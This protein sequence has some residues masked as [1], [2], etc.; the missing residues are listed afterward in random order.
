MLGLLQENIDYLLTLSAL[1]LK[2]MPLCLKTYHAMPFTNID[3]TVPISRN[4]SVR[5]S[6]PS[7]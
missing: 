1:K 4:N 7:R 3:I 5:E 2:M 6:K